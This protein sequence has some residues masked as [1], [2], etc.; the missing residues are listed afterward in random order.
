M[1]VYSKERCFKK[2]LCNKLVLV[3]SNLEEEGNIFK[4]FSNNTSTWQGKI[5]K[6]FIVRIFFTKLEVYIYRLYLR[7]HY[8]CITGVQ[9]A[10]A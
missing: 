2:W 9:C 7:L 3:A 6:A 1:K 10:C 5:T 8:C 4:H